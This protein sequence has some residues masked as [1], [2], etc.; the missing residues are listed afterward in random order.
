MTVNISQIHRLSERFERAEPQVILN[1]AYET[2]GDGLAVVT[3]F[4]ITGIATLHMLQ[5]IAPDLPV[6][7]LDTGFLFPETL[8]LINELEAR[9]QLRLERIKPRQTPQQQARDYG[10]RLWE[11][12]PDRCCHIRKT[13]PLRDAL[14]GYAA[15]ITGLRRDQSPNRA[16]TP[17]IS[18]DSR[19][20]LIKI[21]PFAN[22]TEDMLWTYISAHH[23]PYNPLHDIGYPSIGCWTCTKAVAEQ[24]SLR[25]GRWS[26][27]A[28]SECGIHI[29]VEN[30]YA[31]VVPS[32]LIRRPAI[33]SC[34]I[35]RIVKSR[36]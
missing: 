30:A 18:R 17:I 32:C 20:G 6:L 33:P 3:S 31:E 35:C 19:T 9:F 36:L 8:E 34:C 7:T 10:D 2:F 15:W 28:K 1:W 21:A 5:S 27:R 26:Q 22:W 29:P 25:A 24:D 11:R 14:E 16:N 4:Q 13:I 12:N 23:L